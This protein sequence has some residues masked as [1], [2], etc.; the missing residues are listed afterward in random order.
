MS[1]AAQRRLSAIA[2]QS[3]VTF[4]IECYPGFRSSLGHWRVYLFGVA[5]TRSLS[6]DEQ[7]LLLQACATER[8]RLLILTGLLTG[9]RVTELRAISW[10]HVWHE[11]TGEVR[12]ELTIARRDLKGGRGITTRR[13]VC[14]RTVPLH[15]ELRLA[16][17]NY[18]ASLGPVAQTTALFAAKGSFV[19]ISRVQAHRIIKAA[20]T[21]AGIDTARLA[22]HSLRRSFCRDIFGRSGHDLVACSRAMGHASVLT[23]AL[24]L[25]ADEQKVHSLILGA[26]AP[27]Y[28]SFHGSAALTA[29]P[30]VPALVPDARTSAAHQRWTLPGGMRHALRPTAL[31]PDDVIRD[32]DGHHGCI[33]QPPS[34]KSDLI[35]TERDYLVYWKFDGVYYRCLVDCAADAFVKGTENKHLGMLIGMLSERTIADYRQ[36]VTKRGGNADAAVSQ[37]FAANLTALGARTDHAEGAAIIGRLSSAS[38]EEIISG[39]IT[40]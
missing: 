9:Y 21:R 10:D 40:G 38:P 28:H 23:T 33:Q 13:R 36:A 25:S 12:R 15:E 3:K 1:R 24:Y 37:L 17:R 4:P 5:T 2:A 35:P 8:D 30:S 39:K 6:P 22:C 31:F 14:S 29:P 7:V 11:G 26:A 16:I 34:M 32:A 19:G 27:S 20:A 18:R